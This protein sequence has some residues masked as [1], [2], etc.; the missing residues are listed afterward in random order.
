VG[1]DKQLKA[2]QVEF[3]QLYVRFSSC[4]SCQE[5]VRLPRHFLPARSSFAGEGFSAHKANPLQIKQVY[6]SRKRQFWGLQR[7][8][9]AQSGG[10]FGSLT[11]L[12]Y[13]AHAACFTTGAQPACCWIAHLQ[14]SHHSVSQ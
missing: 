14:P 2:V 9:G 13:N 1:K 3:H 12:T 5:D 6:S 8:I 4:A 10:Q 11:W 7:K